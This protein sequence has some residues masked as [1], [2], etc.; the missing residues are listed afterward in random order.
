MKEEKKTVHDFE[1]VRRLIKI[2]KILQEET[3]ETHTITQSE[4]LLLLRDR[5]CACSERTLTDYLKTI[6]KEL[7]PEDEDGYIHDNA[8]IDDYVIIPKGLEEKFKAREC[9]LTTEGSKK[10][11]LRSLRYNQLLSFDELNQVIEGVLFLKHLDDTSKQK[12]IKKLTNLSSKNYPKHSP[13]VSAT[14]GKVS[15]KIAG[16]YEDSRVDEVALKKNMQMIREAIEAERGAGVKIAFH[17]NG[18]DENKKLQP[19]V[20]ADGNKIRYVVNPY[21]IIMYNGKPYLICAVEP[22]DN[23]AI[24]R[25]DLMSDVTCYTKESLIHKDKMISEKRKPKSEVKG[26]PKEW[27]EK[28]ASKFQ[29]EHLYMYYGEPENITLKLDKERYTLLHDYFGDRYRFVKHLDDRWDCV[30]VKCVPDAMV[31]WAMQCSDVVEVLKPE[32]LRR[33]ILDKCQSL[34]ARYQMDEE[35]SYL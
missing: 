23:V 29:T 4:L 14:T 10:L 13:F 15:T 25:M 28:E 32:D 34:A 17:F 9:G 33:E 20:Y 19:R 2:L 18:Y 30:Q 16:V 8:T 22:H 26:L 6:M 3:D 21:Y 35:E 27:N 5:D 31:S 1:F 7:N 12:L 11:Q 24:Y